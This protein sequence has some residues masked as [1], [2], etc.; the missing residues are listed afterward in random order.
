MQWFHTVPLI[1]PARIRQSY[2]FLPFSFLP[3]LPFHLPGHLRL[4]R[5]LH[6]FSFFHWATQPSRNSNEKFHRHKAFLTF[7]K[8]ALIPSYG[9]S[10]HP[11]LHKCFRRKESLHIS[12]VPIRGLA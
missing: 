6:G 2:F 10:V 4:L 7:A 11:R 1:P 12:V 8:S 3:P 5:F 9:S